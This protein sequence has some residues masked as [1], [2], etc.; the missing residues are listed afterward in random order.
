MKNIIAILLLA[1]LTGCLGVKRVFKKE[2]TKLHTEKL[3][4]I[5][6]SSNVLIKN[7]SIKDRLDVAVPKSKTEDS[8]FNKKIDAQIDQILSRLNTSKSSGDNSYRLKYNKLKRQLEFDANIGA[9]QNETTITNK[10]DMSEVVKKETLETSIYKRIKT[11]PWYL[12]LLLYFIFLD[13]KITALLS[14]FIPQLKGA[15]TLLSIFKKK[16]GN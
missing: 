16:D 8:N 2:Q 4:L 5:R 10:E 13:S 15:S 7:K 3:E 1:T 6:D 12:W 11:M 14:A 9:T